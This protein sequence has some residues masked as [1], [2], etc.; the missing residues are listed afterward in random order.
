MNTKNDE[1]TIIYKFIK[2]KHQNLAKMADEELRKVERNKQILKEMRREKRLKAKKDIKM[3]DYEEDDDEGD[4][5]EEASYDD[6]A[7]LAQV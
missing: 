7:T 5:S 2:A 4:E 1:L 3:S 6:N